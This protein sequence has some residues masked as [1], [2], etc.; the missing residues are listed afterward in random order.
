MQQALLRVRL[1]LEFHKWLLRNCQKK[2][3]FQFFLQSDT[4]MESGFRVQDKVE[5]EAIVR[6]LK[7]LLSH[8]DGTF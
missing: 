3:S 4:S 6:R 1:W 7:L 5:L 2:K 8:S